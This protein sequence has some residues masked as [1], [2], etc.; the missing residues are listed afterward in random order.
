MK[1]G[2]LVKYIDLSPISQNKFFKSRKFGIILEVLS[3][4]YTIRNNIIL[5]LWGDG[6]IEYSTTQ[7]LEVVNESR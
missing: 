4:K 1:V 5:V 3:D 7:L 2:E 6:D